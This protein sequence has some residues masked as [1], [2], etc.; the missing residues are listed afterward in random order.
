MIDRRAIGEVGPRD[1]RRGKFVVQHG[2]AMEVAVHELAA[3]EAV[4]LKGLLGK[5]TA[6]QAAIPKDA[7]LHAAFGEAA[8]RE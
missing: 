8:S 7:V 1:A 3:G 6:L 2:R 5:T 4:T